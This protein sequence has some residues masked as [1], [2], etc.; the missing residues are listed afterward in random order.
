MRGSVSERLPRRN[1]NSLRHCV[2]G[3][4]DGNRVAIRQSLPG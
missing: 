4:T 2:V 1:Q 3:A